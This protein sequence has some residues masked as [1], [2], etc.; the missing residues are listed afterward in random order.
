[1]LSLFK[2]L[3]RIDYSNPSEV[4]DAVK[5]IF[6]NLSSKNRA[7]ATERNYKIILTNQMNRALKN[8]KIP[9]DVMPDFPKTYIF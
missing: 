8:N 9:F 4:E 7:V 3:N 1:M 2:I 6:Y 5:E